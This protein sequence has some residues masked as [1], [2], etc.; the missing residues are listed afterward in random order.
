M[1]R[2][3]EI[4]DYNPFNLNK[5]QIDNPDKYDA[6][7]VN[8]YSIDGIIFGTIGST[9]CITIILPNTNKTFLFSDSSEAIKFYEQLKNEHIHKDIDDEQNQFR[10]I[11]IK[12]Q[13]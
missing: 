8:L 9:H 7:F 13:V 5:E 12:R 10:I 11:D 4:R 1:K 6:T 3:I 2:F